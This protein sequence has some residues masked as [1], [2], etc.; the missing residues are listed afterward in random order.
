ME[1]QAINTQMIN[2]VRKIDADE[3]AIDLYVK[4]QILQALNFY[5]DQVK[6]SKCSSTVQENLSYAKSM[7]LSLPAQ[8]NDLEISAISNH[9]LS[10][11]RQNLMEM[12]QQIKRNKIQMDKYANI[13]KITSHQA[14]HVDRFKPFST[15]LRSDLSLMF[16]TLYTYTEPVK[17]RNVLTSTILPC[18]KRVRSHIANFN[19]QKVTPADVNVVRNVLSEVLDMLEIT[20]ISCTETLEQVA[21]KCKKKMFLGD[22]NHTLNALSHE[23]DIY[24]IDITALSVPVSED[25]L[26][27]IKEKILCFMNVKLPQVPSQNDNI[28]EKKRQLYKEAKF[29]LDNLQ[30][31]N[32]QNLRLSQTEEKISQIVDSNREFEE[33]INLFENVKQIT[34]QIDTINKTVLS[35]RN[36]I[37]KKISGHL[38]AEAAAYA[39][40]KLEVVDDYINYAQKFAFPKHIEMYDIKMGEIRALKNSFENLSADNELCIRERVQVFRDRVEEAATTLEKK[41]GENEETLLSLESLQS[42]LEEILN[43]EDSWTLDAFNS[44]RSKI[45][46]IDSF[47]SKIISKKLEVLKCLHDFERKFYEQHFPETLETI[48]FLLNKYERYTKKLARTNTLAK[49]SQRKQNIAKLQTN[50]TKFL[51]RNSF[52]GN[53][54]TVFD[55]IFDQLWCV[56][57]KNEELNDIIGNLEDLENEVSNAEFETSSEE[58]MHYVAT[59]RSKAA[60]LK[61]PIKGNDTL[62]RISNIEA[63]ILTEES[64]ILLTNILNNDI[65]QLGEEMRSHNYQTDNI[66]EKIDYILILKE[67]IHDVP[68]EFAELEEVK[69]NALEQLYLITHRL[70]KQLAK[71]VFKK[72]QWQN[73]INV[74]SYFKHLRIDGVLDR[75]SVEF[76][77][78]VVSCAK[79]LEDSVNCYLGTKESVD[80][81]IIHESLMRLLEDLDELECDDDALW[82][83]TVKAIEYIKKLK[84]QLLLNASFSD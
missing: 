26:K 78:K 84:K 25:I 57:Q 41:A 73:V 27:P 32:A 60:S 49:F 46:I 55:K 53:L 70:D 2:L 37:L 11:M 6:K 62:N 80:Y 51:Q 81:Y 18:L 20:K 3:G 72:R 4:Q 50:T 45:E 77:E 74:E 35:K 28:K 13:L 5:S 36:E 48:S 82:D 21:Q 47:S 56:L 8:R 29:I 1:I 7:L 65:K 83:A 10:Y 64:K 54:S 71:S 39:R 63:K 44:Y 16:L 42:I 15:K 76:V 12:E 58:T 66:L 75:E 23:L 40:Q 59:L 52:P 31:V 79:I 67:R 24:Q 17:I 19:I 9:E 14:Q 30:N 22:P 33:K 38:M 61:T 34:E 43:S 69:K 68:D